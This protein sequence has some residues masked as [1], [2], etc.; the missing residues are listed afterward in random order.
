MSDEKSGRKEP[1]IAPLEVWGG[2]EY[3][4]NRVGDRY[5]DQ[6]ELSGHVAGDLEMFAELGIRALRCGVLWERHD[7]D[8]SWRWPDE[9]LNAVRQTGMR[10]IVGLLHHGSG[11]RHTNLLDPQFAE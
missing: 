9:H 5:I 4:C 1:E 8:P 10:P 2:A 11:P 3:T 7:R 6:M